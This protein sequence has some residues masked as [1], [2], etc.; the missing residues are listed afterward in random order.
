MESISKQ[1]SNQI[2]EENVS[3]FA[4]PAKSRK[5][6]TSMPKDEYKRMRRE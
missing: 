2:V 6:D 5:R 4:S 3:P 1:N